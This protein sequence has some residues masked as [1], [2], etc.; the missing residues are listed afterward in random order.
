MIKKIYLLIVRG[1]KGLTWCS[2]KDSPH[3]E[4]S[5]KSN[6]RDFS[7]FPQEQRKIF[8]KWAA[9]ILSVSSGSCSHL[10]R[11]GSSELWAFKISPSISQLLDSKEFWLNSTWSDELVPS[12]SKFSSSSLSSDP[13]DDVPQDDL[14]LFD[15]WPF[16]VGY[17]L[18]YLDRTV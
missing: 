15:T 8:L 13:E 11:R 17:F 1:G 7:S 18:R 6:P 16:F 3:I 9:P 14:A 4:I 5:T 2:M 10:A 12:I